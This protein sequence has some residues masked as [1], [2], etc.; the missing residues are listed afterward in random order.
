[1]YFAVQPLSPLKAKD[2]G[3]REI[4]IDATAVDGRES[5]AGYYK[6]TDA[7]K[8][9]QKVCAVQLVMAIAQAHCVSVLAIFCL[10]KC[11]HERFTTHQTWL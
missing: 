11:S 6:Q 8:A 9:F 3:E 1:M 10:F 2:K 7:S 5:S 4:N